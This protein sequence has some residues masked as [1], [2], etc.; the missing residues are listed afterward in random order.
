VLPHPSLVSEGENGV[1]GTEEIGEEGVTVQEAEAEE[2]AGEVVN[3][4]SFGGA[5]LTSVAYDDG[6]FCGSG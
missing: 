5:R 3:R 1:V 4:S 2:V 6:R